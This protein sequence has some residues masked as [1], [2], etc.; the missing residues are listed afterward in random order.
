MIIKRQILL[1]ASLLIMCLLPASVQSAMYYISP[2]GSDTNPG[3]SAKP[4]LTFA[5]A[6]DPARASCG[7]TLLLTN[8]VYGDGTSTGKISI[9]GLICTAGNEL[10]IRALNQR[11]AKINDDGRGKAIYIA[12]SAFII[13]DGLYACSTDN[14]SATSS[15][16]GTPLL[17]TNSHHIHAKNLVGKNPNRYVNSHVFSV[18]FS[19]EIL[20]EDLEGYV[21]H[22]HCIETHQD[23]EVVARRIYCNPRG[24]KIPGGGAVRILSCFPINLSNT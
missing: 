18:H 20:L 4:W 9:S 16:Y 23:S 12:N 21:F 22:R 2:T 5:Y 8:G 1:S 14:I 11:Q 24:G 10:I 3:T 6:I 7:D 15:G 19:Q 17:I 13:I